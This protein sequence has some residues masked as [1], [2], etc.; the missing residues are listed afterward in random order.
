MHRE[1]VLNGSRLDIGAL[2]TY[3]VQDIRRYGDYRI[4]A[5]PCSAN[6]EHMRF[7]DRVNN[8]NICH[9]NHYV[10]EPNLLG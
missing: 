3:F 10:V 2:P 6:R 9:R 1:Y 8:K 7:V 5:V 4:L